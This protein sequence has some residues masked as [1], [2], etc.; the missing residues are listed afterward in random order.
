[1]YTDRYRGVDGLRAVAGISAVISAMLRLLLLAAL[2][3]AQVNSA[4]VSFSTKQEV[5][6]T[7]EV[8]STISLR[9]LSR[10]SMEIVWSPSRER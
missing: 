6:L 2:G 5:L 10:D 9:W 7:E 4:V 1:M 8:N 3:L